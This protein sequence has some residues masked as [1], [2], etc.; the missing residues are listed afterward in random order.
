[1]KKVIFVLVSCG[2][3]LTV[4]GC[5]TGAA[6]GEDGTLKGR[7]SLDVTPM[8]GVLV[9]AKGVNSHI[10]TTVVTE[11]E[12]LYRFPAKRLKPGKYRISTRAAGYDL[13]D[14]GLIDV[15]DDK[16]ISV[17]LKLQK[18]S[19]LADQLMN[20]EWLMS[21]AGTPEHKT[22]LDARLDLLDI[23]RCT[24]CHAFSYVTKNGH[25]AKEWVGVLQRMARHNPGS[26]PIHPTDDPNS[27]RYAQYWDNA[28]EGGEAPPQFQDT[29]N[30]EPRAAN[31][32]SSV[33][34]VQQQAEYL[35]TINLSA[36][37][38]GTWKYPLLTYPRPTGVETNVIIT[39]YDI[40]RFDAQPHDAAVD[41]DGNVWYWDFGS[42]W[43]GRLNP[44]TG[45]MKEWRVPALKPFPPYAPGGLD[46]EIDWEGNPWI[47]LQRRPGAIK[48]EKRTE[49]MIVYMTPNGRDGVG[50]LAMSPN[51]KMVWMGT[52]GIDM[53]KNHIT[54]TWRSPTRGYGLNA[55]S[56]GNLLFLSLF[57]SEIGELDTETGKTAV[58]P[59]PTPGAGARRG[60]VA[61][62]D[63]LWFAEYFGGRIAM[64]DTNTKQFKEW[65]ID[66][67]YV[68]PYAAVKDR[69]GIVWAGGMVTDYIYRLD[70][71]TGQIKKYLLP[72]LNSN[73]RRIDVDNS[74]SPVSIW[75]GENHHARLARIEVLDGPK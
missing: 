66:V 6:S 39:E 26:S 64:F 33:L 56:K 71:A 47:A 69:N 27:P 15:A 75:V 32:T 60:F 17:D 3:A 55:T 46:L 72:T 21:I 59:L 8:E 54:K 30:W 13:Q 28:G 43:L 35:A 68:D 57:N 5:Y 34:P 12:G 24:M 37:P 41:P 2:L 38:M 50:F 18:T 25:D 44:R 49:Q 10:T 40:P 67:P 31:G 23:N 19:T 16:S 36:D 7:V 65:P 20:G 4:I 73:I 11:H 61:K 48:F 42:D 51:T 62:D 14:P 45:E 53:T 22:G 9:S 70:P 52:N 63:R 74:T 58:Y 1:M 29:E